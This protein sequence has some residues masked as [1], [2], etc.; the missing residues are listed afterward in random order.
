MTVI[1]RIIALTLSCGGPQSQP[2]ALL[3][4]G[5]VA[6]VAVADITPPVGSRLC[7]YFNE[8]VSTAVHDPLQAKA[9][10]FAQGD[11]QMA[12]VFCDL[13]SITHE[14][15][16]RARDLASRKTGIPAANIAIVGTH[17]HTGPLYADALR[18]HLHK[19][20]IAKHGR[21][22]CEAVDYP[23]VLVDRLAE[24]IARAKA[25]ARP[26][27]LQAG[28]IAQTPL[29]SFNR[30]FHVKDGSVRFNPGQMNP[31]IVRPAGPIDPSV[32]ILLLSDADTDRRLA[33]LTS[34]ALHLD[35]TGGTQYSADYP[36]Y[37]EQA[38]RQSWGPELVSLFGTGCCG[39]VNHID[40][41]VKG[42]RT[43]QEIGTQLANTVQAALPKLRPIDQPALAAKS[44]TVDAP[45]QQ[46]S[47]QELAKAEKD[48]D[49][50]GG[51]KMAFLDQVK[52]YKIVSLGRLKGPTL[53][54]EVQAF[55]LGPDLAVVTLPGEV[56]VE[57]S[58]AIKQASPFK[59]TF[60]IELAN[61]SIHYVPTKKAFA[62]G[63]YETVNSMIEPG[64]GEMMTAAA[65]GALKSLAP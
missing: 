41:T 40:V 38:L 56:F 50:I 42:R 15:S 45:L 43:A 35:T 10:V 11:T 39:D 32:S 4:G 14:V 64:G 1:L 23:A 46:F 29:L 44:A 30:R 54:L 37:L 60:V 26:A 36:F 5:L 65:I 52:A 61:D 2:Q 59:T 9:V 57:F 7:G 27:S 22:P 16:S 8:R 47:P 48:M 49:A 62:E 20:A 3:P 17:T 51:T 34:F 6:G 58:L 33:S 18:D 55:R 12:L 19:V 53:P 13:I 21:D 28:S 24:V 31:D 63:S 25:A